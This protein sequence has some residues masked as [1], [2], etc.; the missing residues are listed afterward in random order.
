MK[1]ERHHGDTGQ[2]ERWKKAQRLTA[3]QQKLDRLNGKR[4]PGDELSGFFHLGTVGQAGKASARLNRRRD[5]A[6]EQRAADAKE[7]GNLQLKINAARWTLSQPVPQPKPAKVPR[8]KPEPTERERAIYEHVYYGTLEQDAPEDW[9]SGEVY[10]VRQKY[11][12]GMPKPRTAEG[13]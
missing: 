9:T 1:E 12:N 2:L 11:R 3:M 6:I 10:A 7:V 13:A 8:P 5:A 4:Y